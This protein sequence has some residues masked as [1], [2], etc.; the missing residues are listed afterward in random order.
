MFFLPII[1]GFPTEVF[2]TASLLRSPGLFKV[3]LQVLTVLQFSWS[4][5]FRWSP[6]LPTFLDFWG[7]YHEF[8][9]LLV[10]LTTSCSV[11]FLLSGKI[12]VFVIRFVFF[13]FPPWSNRTAKSTSCWL[14]VGMVFWLGL[15]VLLISQCPRKIYASHFLGQILV[16]AFTIS[17]HG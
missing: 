11:S 2:V 7:L 15:G 1:M 14:K 5:F 13:Y 3:F 8:Q 17:V 9:L 4:R 16:C 6:Y 10:S 12:Q